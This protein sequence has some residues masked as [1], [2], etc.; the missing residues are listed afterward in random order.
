MDKITTREIYQQWYRI[1]RIIA[2]GGLHELKFK[3]NEDICFACYP[4][5]AALQSVETHKSVRFTGWIFAHK[6]NRWDGK[7]RNTEWGDIPF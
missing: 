5:Y 1:G 2:R 7:T 4:V 3:M 6:K